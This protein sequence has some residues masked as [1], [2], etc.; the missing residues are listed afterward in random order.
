MLYAGYFFFMLFLA[1]ISLPFLQSLAF[2]HVCGVNNLIFTI[3][4][5]Y[6][7]HIKTHVIL[8]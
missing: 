8:I 5:G 2:T 3:A 4:N 1:P 7:D 6:C